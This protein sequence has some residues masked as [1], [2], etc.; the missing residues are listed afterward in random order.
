MKW[1]FRRNQSPRIVAPAAIESAA[2][3]PAVMVQRNRRGLLGMLKTAG[4]A[5]VAATRLGAIVQHN[6]PV[7]HAGTAGNFSSVFSPPA[8]TA[9][10]TDGAYGVRA[11]S[12]TTIGVFG[13]STSG[14]GVFGTSNSD[15]G[16]YGNGNSSA[17]VFGYS[18]DSY[19]VYGYG[20]NNSGVYGYGYSNI[21]VTG[22]SE[23]DYGVYGTSNGSIGVIGVS[24]GTHGVF[25]LSDNYSGVYSLSYSTTQPS[26]YATGG[27]VAGVFDGN[28]QVNGS[29]SKAGGSFLIDHPLN[30]S[31]KKLYHSFVESPDMKNIY[32][33][34]V[35]LDQHGRVV[36]TLPD[37]FSAL[38]R[39]FCYQLT[40]LGSFAPV[41][42]MQKIEN[43]QFTIG[44]EPGMEVSW[45]VTGIRQD[46]WAQKYRI[47]VE[48]EKSA[49]EQGLYYHPELYGQSVSKG[50]QHKPEV[51]LPPRQTAQAH[52]HPK[53]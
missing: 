44:G 43:N 47:P 19:G 34:V 3:E 35:T 21:G 1:K 36:V 4:V 15:Y 23:N 24:G 50:I 53:S 17:G 51:P 41:C 16:V 42:I 8:V 32:D 37:W 12:D 6:A 28:V 22:F 49:A 45:Q 26:L 33:G 10:G 7:A 38:N 9:I 52:P 2:T 29:L 25:G 39:D 48:E 11:T 31:N 30:P 20:N 27:S 13:T 46:A 18:Y 5:V 40:G 14:Y